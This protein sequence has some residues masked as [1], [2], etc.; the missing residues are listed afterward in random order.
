M[1]SAETEL[2]K[3][4]LACFN[5]LLAWLNVVQM[6]TP[7]CLGL[8]KLPERTERKKITLRTQKHCFL[9]KFFLVFSKTEPHEFEL[10]LSALSN[11][12]SCITL[13]F[14]WGHL[15]LLLSQWCP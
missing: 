12:D 6:A 1:F 5:G 9:G 13:L 3:D 10:Y 4:A 11:S 7:Y 14:L 2:D 8:D 15:N